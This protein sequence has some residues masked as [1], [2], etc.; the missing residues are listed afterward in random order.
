MFLVSDTTR[1]KGVG[2][3]TL[4]TQE[5]AGTPPAF[6]YKLQ[7]PELGLR[8]ETSNQQRNTRAST[9]LSNGEPVLVVDALFFF[10]LEDICT[11]FNN[12]TNK[13]VFALSLA[14]FKLL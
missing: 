14:C 12:N 6:D 7:G 9:S 11:N 4:S 1:E 5:A 8:S 10:P 3:V 13:T 2:D